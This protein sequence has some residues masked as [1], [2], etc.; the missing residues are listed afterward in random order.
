MIGLTAEEKVI[1]N[2]GFFHGFKDDVE[3]PF[4]TTQ[5]GLALSLDLRRSHVSI[6]L[7]GLKKKGLVIERLSHVRK[8]A[9]R[10]KV[11][12]LTEKGIQSSE[13]LRNRLYEE[14]V[15][16]KDG[17]KE[18]KM[19][20]KALLKALPGKPN[21]IKA[22]A[23]ITNDIFDLGMFKMK[24]EDRGVDFS[25]LLP[26][27]RYFF[28]REEE[29]GILKEFVESKNKRIFALKGIAGIGKT[30]LLTKFV[31]ELKGWEILMYRVCEWSTLRN[32]LMRLAEFLAF[33]GRRDLLS[34]LKS[35]EVPNIEDSVAIASRGL[36]GLKTFLVFD[37]VHNANENI[38]MF[39]RALTESSNALKDSKLVV[40]GRTIPAFYSRK[41]VKVRGAVEEMRLK[42]LDKEAAK[43]I[44]RVQREGEDR[45]FSALYK[46]SKGHPLFLELLALNGTVSTKTDVK[47]YIYEEIYS[48]LSKGEKKLLGM[49][50]VFRYPMKPEIF[51]VDEDVDYDVLEELTEKSLIH[52]SG[53]ACELHELLKEFFYARLRPKSRARYHLNATNY[54]E[55]EEGPLAHIESIYHLAKA[56]EFVNA[57]KKA[58]EEGIDLITKGYQE[59]LLKLLQSFKEKNIGKD[60]WARILF[61][62][63]EILTMLG[64]WKSAQGCHTEA[65]RISKELNNKE[66]LA[67]G[68][69]ELGV[70]HYRRGEW[71]KALE[72]YQK[73][74]ELSKKEG[75]K[76]REAKLYNTMGIVHWRK[77]G[78]RKAAEFYKKSLLIYK[79][80]RDS[81][82]IAG[83][84]N[85]L[86][87]VH[88][89]LRE[90]DK[91]LGNYIKSLEISQK[92]E[93]KRTVAIL[94]NNIGEVYRV[95]GE[96]A[97]AL[98]YYE[99]SL[100]LS[101]GLDFKWQIAEVY[102]NLGR[103]SKGKNRKEHLKKALELFIQLGAKKDVEEVKK[104]QKK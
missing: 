28:G 43:E 20:F 4:E 70:M 42:G 93:D 11:Y 99:R 36:S 97:E 3:A 5:A 15:I 103:I 55:R 7:S 13:K 53:N 61:L 21:P 72:R 75:F 23:H 38:V 24:S 91:A 10:K 76:E 100:E 67:Q 68:F 71:D 46:L 77:G 34:Y 48:R 32:V 6:A 74:L 58:V 25:D 45:D 98:R 66:G 88:W 64:D 41:D 79:K 69:Y 59:E 14:E 40:A 65:L 31:S 82:G 33:K 8:S 87:I 95:K 27:I 19:K 50:S 29:L 80:L 85:N 44:L 54:Y 1:I 102:R 12:F 90:L 60:Y 89:E 57:S 101:K 86:G 47:R 96:K 104:M 81:R 52:R 92:L 73:A 94:Y 49:A 16:F 2:L 17:L 26:E 83:A 9:R 22:L 78:L 84:Y 51:L 30:T 63:G 39:F 35:Q 18:E 62:K 37:D 56:N